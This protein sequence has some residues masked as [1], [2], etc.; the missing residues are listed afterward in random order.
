MC[1]LL[2]RMSSNKLMV[3]NPSTLISPVDAPLVIQELKCDTNTSPRRLV[4][5]LLHQI[6]LSTVVSIGTGNEATPHREVTT[7]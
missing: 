2:P 4:T 7:T 6:S 5:H 1:M 3:W